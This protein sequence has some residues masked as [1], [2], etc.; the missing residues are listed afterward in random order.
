MKEGER[1]SIYTALGL[2]GEAGEIAEKVK[3]VLRDH[4][5]DFSKLDK[6][7]I[8]KELGD[9]LWY[10]SAFAHSIG[11]SLDDIARGN[12]EKLSS[13]KTRGVIRGSG[14]NR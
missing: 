12:I 7:D 3:K 13:R 6:D 4:D 10:V 2:N 8:S 5:G 9:V 14:D 11:L 1:L